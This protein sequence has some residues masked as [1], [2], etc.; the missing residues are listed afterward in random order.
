[1]AT[2]TKTTNTPDQAHAEAAG[3]KWLAAATPEAE[4]SVVKVV[5]VSGTTLVEQRVETVRPDPESAFE[6]GRI[7]RG[8]HEA[9]AEAFGAPPEGWTGKNYIGRVEQSC[10]PRDNW[11]EFYTEQRVLPFARR[12]HLQ[13]EI[14]QLVE[15]ACGGIVKHADAP[16]FDVP[17]AR[18]HG[19]LW[20]GN[21][22]FSTDGVVMID[23]AAHGGHP[24]TDLAMLELFGTPHLVDILAG[25]GNPDVDFALHQLH[26]LAVH[27]MTHGTAYHRPLADAAAEVVQR[28]G[29]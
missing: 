8:I 3:L 13:P 6:F 2:F 25:Y 12:A 27:A 23:P 22:L 7:L 14:E 26:P 9:G 24:H 11:A 18:I 1:M 5:E 19:D 15:K 4:K 29:D 17:P 28:Y 21:V 10:T 16:E 20:A